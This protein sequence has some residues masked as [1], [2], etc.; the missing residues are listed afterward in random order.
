MT[1]SSVSNAGDTDSPI[2][3]YRNITM[4]QQQHEQWLLKR[5]TQQQHATGTVRASS[6]TITHLGRVSPTATT[7][8]GRVSPTACFSCCWNRAMG[9]IRAIAGQA[10]MS[11]AKITA[12]SQQWRAVCC[13]NRGLNQQNRGKWVLL[14]VF[15][16]RHSIFSKML[17]E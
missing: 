17:Q 7:H 14:F 13:R 9:K 6:T 8:L 15:T 5:Q 11:A 4:K 10:R 16:G 1:S 2:V 12:G 3:C